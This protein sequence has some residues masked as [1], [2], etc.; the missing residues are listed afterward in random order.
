MGKKLEWRQAA[1][2]AITVLFFVFQAYLALIKQFATMLQAPLHLLFALTLVYLYNPPDKK[3]RKNLQKKKGDGVTE[4]ELNRFAWSRWIDIIIYVCVVFQ[5]YYILTRYQTLIDHVMFISPVDTLD[6]A[7]MVIT[8]VL[9]LEAVRRTLGAVLFG[10]ILLFVVYAW[11]APYLPGILYTRGKDAAVMLKQFT[12]GMTMGTSGIFGSPLQTSA[13]SLFYFIVFGAF[14]SA[15]G[16]GQL[17]IDMGMKVSNKGSGGPAK[18]AVISSGLMGMISGS[19]VANVATT[20]VMTIPMMKKVGYEPEEAGAVEAVASTGG[21][22]MPPIMG[23]GAFIMAEM[24]G[25]SYG[26]VA[27]GAIIPAVAYYFAVFVLVDRLAAKRASRLD[28]SVD[29]TIKVDR[30]ILPRLYL[31]LPAIVLVV[32]IIKGFSLMRAGTVGIFGCLICNV[33]SYFVNEKKDFVGLKGVWECC[34]DGAKQAAEIAI[35]TA[36]CGI[37]INVVTGQTA[38]ATNLSSVISGLGT[39]HLFVALLIGMV[40]CM[41]LGM[42]LPTV[43]AYLVG[44]ILFVPCIRPILIDGGMAAETANLCANMF[45]FYYGIMA[46]ITPPVCVASY[47]AAGIADANAMKTG[48]KGFTFAMVGFLDPFV[49]GYNP[50]ILLVRSAAEIALGAAKLLCGT[51]FLALVVS[52]YFKTELNVVERAVLFVAALCLISPELITSIVGV[53]LGIALLFVNASRKK[54]AVKAA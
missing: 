3:Y 11:T 33:I 38:L 28:G 43:A 31:L 19:A 41:L 8:V 47:T 32:F 27:A 45:V 23:V 37:I 51:Y 42:A 10:F 50:A 5:L 22:V 4:Q 14:F 1:A 49:Y 35:P 16:G 29:T 30:K 15:M 18:A 40:G 17:L 2:I 6:I 7:F 39:D 20:G 52:G 36:A 26:R 46:Q 53:I 9:L 54:K 21:Q 48:L 24:L 34:M 12:E 25:I 44:V 13:N